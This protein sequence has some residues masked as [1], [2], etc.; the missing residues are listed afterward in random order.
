MMKKKI[1]FQY[2]LPYF[3]C[4]EV[5]RIISMHISMA[6]SYRENIRPQKMNM[7]LI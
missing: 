3:F 1:L 5:V 7:F 4:L 2:C 6:I